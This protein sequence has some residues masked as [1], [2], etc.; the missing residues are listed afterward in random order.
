M[1]IL[2]IHK[3]NREGEH[4]SYYPM[5]H[6]Y[7]PYIIHGNDKDGS[8]LCRSLGVCILVRYGQRM[9]CVVS[10]TASRVAVL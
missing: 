2:Y 4:Y 7:V 10:R 9:W 6:I 3:N 5:V 1:Y 8:I